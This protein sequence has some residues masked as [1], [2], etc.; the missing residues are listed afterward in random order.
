MIVIIVMVILAVVV[1]VFVVPKLIKLFGDVA[2]LPMATRILVGA[3][4]L[5]LH[6]WPLLAAG[7]GIVIGGFVFWKKT[8]WGARQW[9]WFLLS[10]PIVGTILKGMILSRVTRIFGF[11]IASGVP[12]VEGLKISSH[13]AGN[14]IYEEKLLL[15][16]DDLSKGISIAEN[17]S[18]NEKLF[19]PML[20]NMISIGERT[21]SLEK[22]MIRIADFYEDELD[23]KIG[24]LAKLMEPF[25][26]AFIAAGAVFMIL[27]IY[28][29][30]LKMNDKVLG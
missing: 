25:I 18:D 13:I 19:P 15:A 14:P 20:I 30:I 17:L 10:I 12:I 8:P 7:V 29:P 9:S 1:I 3:S 16:S 2:N 27:A 24:M 22:I 5:V 26:L 4:N 11:L 21:A 23:R 28:L 6:K